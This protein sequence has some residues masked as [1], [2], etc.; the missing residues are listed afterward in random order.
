LLLANGVLAASGLPA[1]LGSRRSE[2][3]QRLANLLVGVGCAAGLVGAAAGLR[4]AG[5]AV[6]LVGVPGIGTGFALG[7]DSLSAFFLVPI[8]LVGG[9][10]SIY[11][12]AYWR[13][14]EHPANGRKLRF[15]YGLEVAALAQVVLARDGLSFLVSWEVMA[16]AAYFLITTEGDDRE[17]RRAGWLYLVYTH[18]G[19]LALVALFALLADASGG[20]LLRPAGLAGPGGAG[21][22]IF[23][24]A[25]VGF[26]IKAGLM[27]LH[28]WLP[29]AHANAP[30]HVSALLSGVLIKLGVYGLLRVTSLFAELPLAWGAAVLCL[31]LVSSLA[32]VAFA[33][34]Q[35]DLKRLLAYHSIENVG[36][37]TLGLGIAML[38]RSA[39]EPAWV[40]LGLGGCLLHV[41]N[42]A[43]FKPLL[44]LGAG[45]VVHGVGTREIDRTGGLAQRM[46][47]TA[48]LF[49]LGAMAICGLP[50]LNGFASELL[51]YLGLFRTALASGEQQWA[52]GLLGI[53]VL[54]MVGGLALACFVKVF[55]VVFLGEP[56]SPACQGAHD[57]PR[58]MVIPM[59]LLAAGCLALGV[60]PWAA[61]PA[62][63]AS[64]A[65][66]ASGAAGSAAS[67]VELA[68]LHALTAVA[69][70]LLGLSAVLALP[71]AHFARSPKSQRGRP[72]WGCGYAGA[73]PRLQYTGASFAQMLVG[74]FRWAL[75]PRIDRPALPGIFPAAAPLAV[76][77]GDPVLER[78]VSWSARV[79]RACLAL[80]FLQ[81]GPVQRQLLYVVGALAALLLLSLL[82]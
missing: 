32:G 70:A 55:G 12:L 81:H 37:I 68:P 41:W 59:G 20:Y 62:L 43:L 44:F 53:P 74:L 77:V 72:T 21:W 3:G 51:L 76:H 4:A 25:L 50:P 14:S 30:S 66:W 7:L 58:A 31:G 8:Y 47:V 57:P 73:S 79:E 67:L 54:A 60:A 16:L 46:P 82:A 17:T 11:G 23:A 5:Q 27:P 56:R 24:L 69:L 48:A 33:L 26:G 2:A 29:G 52:V 45:A 19:T 40:A 35:H 6:Q 49:G 38:G 22:A 39:G 78:L 28:S 65:A 18:A 36:I 34:G 9:L 13:Q 80:R 75:A 1:L 64:V 15:F 61:A 71:L 63:E 10:G 42:H